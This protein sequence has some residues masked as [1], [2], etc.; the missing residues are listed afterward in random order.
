MLKSHWPIVVEINTIIVSS[1]DWNSLICANINE[2]R[3][4]NTKSCKIQRRQKVSNCLNK[5][6]IIL[7]VGPK[8]FVSFN[9]TKHL[10]QIRPASIASRKSNLN[11]FLSEKSSVMFN[12]KICLGE[13]ASSMSGLFP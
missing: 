2:A 8:A 4:V 9:I 10:S 1:N 3:H 7:I 5:V 12:S 13:F 11:L 6:V